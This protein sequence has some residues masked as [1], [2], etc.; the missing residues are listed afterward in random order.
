MPSP[1][2]RKPSTKAKRIYWVD[3][4][5]KG[6]RLLVFDGGYYGGD[7]HVY[8]Y[9]ESFDRKK[10]VA[11]MEKRLRGD[12]RADLVGSWVEKKFGHYVPLGLK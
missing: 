3:E 2:S 10:V 11:E 9:R 8:E 7:I 12:E 5:L 6:G 4:P 1:K